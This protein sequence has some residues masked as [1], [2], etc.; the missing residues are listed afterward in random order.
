M[1][2]VVRR[3]G[4][5]AF[6]TISLIAILFC[7]KQYMAE[8][9][10]IAAVLKVDIVADG[11]TETL[12]LWKSDDGNYYC[13]LPTYADLSQTY[14]RINTIRKV[15]LD[16]DE[17]SDGQ[18]LKDIELEK[19][20]CLQVGRGIYQLEFMQSANVAA[21]YIDTQS[22]SMDNVYASKENEE[23]M[24]ITVFDE[25]GGGELHQ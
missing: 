19:E 2:E 10:K 6:M 21:I 24:N 11:T 1:N 5:L 15:C 12:S 16:G 18:P 20:Y 9:D 4:C 25:S 8:T 3:Y 22:G 17:V 7:V 13:F 23:N 14:L